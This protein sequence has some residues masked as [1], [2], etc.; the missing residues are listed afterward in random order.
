MVNQNESWVYCEKCGKKLMKRRENG[1]FIF[2]F[3][4]NKD[5][6]DVLVDIEI[7][8]SVKIKCFREEKGKECGHVNVLS[9]FPQA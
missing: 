3:G 9:F 2:R 7:L 1:V 4:R 5:K 6:S 8:G